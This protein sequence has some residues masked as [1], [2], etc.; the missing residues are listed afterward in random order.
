[1]VLGDVGRC[2]VIESEEEV[3]ID[4]VVGDGSE[5]FLDIDGDGV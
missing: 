5:R 2:G 4:G 3:T 1:V